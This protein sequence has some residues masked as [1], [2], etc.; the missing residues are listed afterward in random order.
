MKDTTRESPHRRP[1]REVLDLLAASETPA[2]A[3]DAGARVIYWNRAAERLLGRPATASLGR[4]CYEVL[5]GT[6]V[7]GNRFCYESCPVVTMTQRGETVRRFELVVHPQSGPERAT[8]VNILKLPGARPDQITLLHLLEPIDKESRLARAL[9]ALGATPTTEPP[10]HGLPSSDE[11]PKAPPGPPLTQ[12]E[13]QVLGAIARGLQNKEIAQELGI[14]L[15]T[16][17]NH[18]HNILEK[19][20]VHSKLEAVSLAFRRGWVRPA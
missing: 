11:D 18:V 16:V 10:H 5:G 17:R 14:S 9:E 19:L 7:F 12:R 20:E 13:R 3:T 15:A 4:A 6:D 2:I 8:N 1:G